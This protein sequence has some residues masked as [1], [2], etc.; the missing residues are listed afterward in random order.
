MTNEKF[1]V[2][3]TKKGDGKI[4]T[5]QGDTYKQ[6]QILEVGTHITHAAYETFIE[7]GWINDAREGD[8]V[9]YTPAPDG[10]TENDRL[11]GKVTEQLAKEQQEALAKKAAELAE[12]PDD[13]L[14]KAKELL[15]A[16]AAAKSAKNA[17]TAK[18]A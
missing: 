12:I 9:T 2:E 15:A 18:D 14:A 8:K 16:E 13:V 6:R 5:G 17:K 10:F 1:L 4:H 11:A 3:I 7:E